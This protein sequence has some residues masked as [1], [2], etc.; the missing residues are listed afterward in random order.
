MSKEALNEKLN[1]EFD[2]ALAPAVAFEEF[3]LNVFGY[4]ELIHRTFLAISTAVKGS[5]DLLSE[6][7]F[8]LSCGW[9]LYH[10]YFNILRSHTNVARSLEAFDDVL[11]KDIS[12]PGPIADYLNLLG[13]YKDDASI[14]ILPKIYLP[15]FDAAA[16]AGTVP[17]TDF[18]NN[19]ELNKFTAFFPFA[20]YVRRM[21]QQAGNPLYAN[22]AHWMKERVNLAPP[23]PVFADADDARIQNLGCYCYAQETKNMTQKRIAALNANY[24]GRFA[25]VD[26][27][28][29]RCY[30]NYECMEK[31]ALWCS[32]VQDRYTVK[33]LK[34]DTIGTKAVAAYCTPLNGD[35]ADVP[36]EY[37]FNTGL[38]LTKSEMIIAVI[39]KFR[40]AIER[41]ENCT[42]Q[43]AQNDSMDT[44]NTSPASFNAP[45]RLSLSAPRDVQSTV[46]AF[47]LSY[48][49][50]R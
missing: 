41:D 7:E 12:V 10:R 4:Q 27:I 25:P 19:R 20:M 24:A 50:K 46:L 32:Y 38:S 48:I 37:E 35:P 13:C 34:M 43:L 33:K 28:R 23:N 44:V 2:V 21:F 45:A 31:F 16:S 36:T 29:G 30:Y 26:N 49:T 39:M 40:I 1:I 6:E 11:S 18:G 17:V 15:N 42:D 22:D 14:K 9:L 47:V 3:D 8:A 5:E